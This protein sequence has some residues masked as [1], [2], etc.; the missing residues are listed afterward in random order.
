M[1]TVRVGVFL[2]ILFTL[3]YTQVT[4]QQLTFPDQ[5]SNYYSSEFAYS[6]SDPSIVYLLDDS[7]YKSIDGGNNWNN[8]G[9]GIQFRY[10]SRIIVDPTNPDIVYIQ[11]EGIYQSRNGGTSFTQITNTASAF[12]VDLNGRIY[13]SS[14]R[15]SSPYY[16][17]KYSDDHGASWTSI[18]SSY[19]PTELIKCSKT[20]SLIYVLKDYLPTDTLLPGEGIYRTTNG[21]LPLDSWEHVQNM[22]FHNYCM[23]FIDQTNENIS[24][25]VDANNKVFKTVDGFSNISEISSFITNID[26]SGNIYIANSNGIPKSTDKG[27][28]FQQTA[29]YEEL[30]LY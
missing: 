30:K 4:W 11:Q 17:L 25:L 18:D 3:A 23:L 22:T 13:H 2:F 19:L 21:T 6:K 27:V 20:S 1:K 28:S 8:T 24:Y 29:N 7:L 5:L 16:D 9:N 15:G 10:A 26:V 12:D 14:R